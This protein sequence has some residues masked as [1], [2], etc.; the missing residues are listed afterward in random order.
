MP[1]DSEVRVVLVYPEVL[2]TYGDQGNAMAIAHRARARGIDCSV[3]A[4]GLHDPL[5][6]AADIYLV[7][8]GEDASMLLAWRRLVHDGGLLR[9]LD[10]GATC[11]GVCA[12]LQLLSR[13]FVG[14]EGGRRAGLGVL[15][16][17]CGRLP[18]PRAVGEV[19]AECEGVVGAG[20]LTGFENHQGGCATR[21][22]GEP[23]G[24]S[25][26]G[27]RQRRPAHRGCGAGTRRGHLPARSG[28]GPQRL[29]RRPPARAGGR[30]A[31][32]LRRRAGAPAAGGASRGCPRRPSWAPAA[33]APLTG[34]RAVR[35]GIRRS[36][37]ASP[38]A[39]AHRAPRGRGAASCR[40]SPWRTAP[41]SR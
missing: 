40:G 7:G 23:A 21:A 30:R 15:D 33:P 24:P 8:G 36:A 18:G 35:V 22:G 25:R 20:F 34:R 41:R 27:H 17:H 19:L 10:R 16:L 38:C 26:V 11:L 39:R 4:V 14:P 6:R 9:A 12:G 2:G 3:V 5:P 13:S 31:A 1:A 37:R 28:A 32:R 29:A